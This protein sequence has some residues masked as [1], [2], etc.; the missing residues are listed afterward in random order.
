MIAK[1]YRNIVP[2]G[3]RASIA[4]WKKKKENRKVLKKIKGGGYPYQ[5]ECEYMLKK[6]A[7]YTMPYPWIEKYRNDNVKVYFDFKRKMPY[8]QIDNESK[9][10]YFPRRW[11]KKYIQRYY[12]SIICE[13]DPKSPHYYFDKEDVWFDKNTVFVDVGAAEGFISL[14]IIDKVKRVILLECDVNWIRPLK[15]T[16]EKWQDKVTIVSKC[17]G[18]MNDGNTC[19]VDTFIDDETEK[20]AVK[21]DV[22]GTEMS[23]IKGCRKLRDIDQVRAYICLYHNDKDEEKIAPFLKNMGF[24]TTTSDTYMFYKF[25]GEKEYSFRH[26]VLKCEKNKI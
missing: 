9:K 15:A 21:M 10:I 8:C 2:I 26:G 16:F 17:A 25:T 24:T 4:D 19:R 6:G 12:N 11:N 5:T 13:Q 1:I 22:E 18:E 23:V 3:I 14:Q 7:I 20:I